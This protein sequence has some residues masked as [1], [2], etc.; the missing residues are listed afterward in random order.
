MT[1][2]NIF[3]HGLA[4]IIISVFM[5][6]AL[7]SANTPDTKS[8]ET[9]L[10]ETGVKVLS[11]V[12]QSTGIVYDMPSP[13]KKPYIVLGLVFASSTTVFDANGKEISDQE[14]IITLLLR[15]AEKLDGQDILNLRVDQN[16][17]WTE[18]TTKSNT[19]PS[20]EIIVLTKTVIYTGSALAIKYID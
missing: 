17:T 13:E 3:K 1:G 7:G 4:L 2:K 9:N 18:T 11:S 20:S 12:T 10:I 8:V 15:E 14:G 19:I 6:L 5:F 16:V